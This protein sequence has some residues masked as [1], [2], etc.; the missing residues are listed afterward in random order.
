ML[1]AIQIFKYNFPLWNS[2]YIFIYE[3]ADF[4]FG[5]ETNNLFRGKKQPINFR[6]RNSNSYD[7]AERFLGTKRFGYEAAETADFYFG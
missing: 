7:T 3:T 4:Y 5:Y 1:P 2:R 6:V